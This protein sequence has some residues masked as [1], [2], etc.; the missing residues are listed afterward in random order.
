MFMDHHGLSKQG[1]MAG[2]TLGFCKSPRTIQNKKQITS[3]EHKNT[4]ATIL[5]S[6]SITVHIS[7]LII[8]LTI[9]SPTCTVDNYG[10]P[11]VDFI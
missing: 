7:K 4:V 5:N 9:G 6:V 2:Q 10:L 8:S 3:K 1:Q 11:T